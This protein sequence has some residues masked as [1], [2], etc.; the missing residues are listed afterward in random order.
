MTKDQV[1]SQVVYKILQAKDLIDDIAGE[2]LVEVVESMDELVLFINTV[3]YE[4]DHE[5]TLVLVPTED[6]SKLKLMYQ[7]GAGYEGLIG[8]LTVELT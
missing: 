1:R 4:E 6:P 3:R 7:D 5:R 8:I 2:G